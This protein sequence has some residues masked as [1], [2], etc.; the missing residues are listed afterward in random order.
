MYSKQQD[1]ELGRKLSAQVRSQADIVQNRTLQN[2]IERLGRRLAATP[3]ASGYPYT[4][5]LVNDN[6]VNAFALPGGPVFVNTGLIKAADN[7]AQLAGVLAHEIA[8]VKLRHATSE[9]SKAELLQLPAA[10]A[11]AVIGQGSA[12][13]QLGEAG[14]GL[15]LNMI[16]LR[17]SRE[18]ESEADALG[19]RIMSEAGY[20]P[21][22]MARFFEKLQSEGGA[23]AP[24]F[25]SDHPNPG[26]RTQAVEAEIRTFPRRRYTAST[27][28]FREAK[29][30][31]NELPAP[32]KR[33]AA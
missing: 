18:A 13:G 31:V 3:A 8:H 33:Q 30:R 11:G 14:L 23:R 20:N 21:I 7:E 17:Y 19:A 25:L 16:V 28:E 9:A 24:Q 1:I 27:G 6:S 10:V 22:E 15:G 29:T 26:N 4:F 5:T 32:R 2:Y 12:A